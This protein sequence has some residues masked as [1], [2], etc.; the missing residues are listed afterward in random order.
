MEDY[1][2]EQVVSADGSIVMDKD[3]VYV[4]HGEVMQIDY[5]H[6]V[7]PDEGPVAQMMQYKLPSL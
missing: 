4:I 1:D 7:R 3:W 5:F 2:L 6:G